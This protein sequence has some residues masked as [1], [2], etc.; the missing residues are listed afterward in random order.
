MKFYD[1]WEKLSGS[2]QEIVLKA[3]GDNFVANC[4]Y[5]LPKDFDENEVKAITWYDKALW[6]EVGV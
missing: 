4:K 1:L 2:E 5:G 6:I 3:G